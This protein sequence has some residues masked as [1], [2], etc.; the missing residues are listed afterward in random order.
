MK[1]RLL[2]GCLCIFFAFIVSLSGFLYLN[3]ECKKMVA[4]TETL[5][6][7]SDE[8]ELTTQVGDLLER[9]ESCRM[10][11]GALLKH[12]DAD[13]LT[14]EFL[15]LGQDAESG[16]VGG[17]TLR[18]RELNALLQVILSGEKPDFENIL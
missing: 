2:A 10:L 11:F 17:M 8:T 7:V 4:Y 6:S 5:L 16:N 12:T 13:E 15:L 14:R 3:S 1:A 9:W 18:L